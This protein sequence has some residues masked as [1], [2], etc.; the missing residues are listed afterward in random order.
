MGQEGA[1]LVLA[2]GNSKLRDME[3]ASS[4]SQLALAVAWCHWHGTGLTGML[5]T[6]RAVPVALGQARCP[7]ACGRARHSGS[8]WHCG[9]PGQVRYE[10]NPA[11]GDGAR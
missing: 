4:W 8:G 5:L 7:P 6:K 2:E 3:R 10:H 9:W 11:E 1:S